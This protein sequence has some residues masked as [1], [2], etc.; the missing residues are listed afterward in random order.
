MTLEE[1]IELM[2]EL[3]QN[4][5]RADIS[6]PVGLYIETK[7]F[8]FYQ[9]TYGE[10]LAEML[11]NVLQKY[12]IETVDKANAKLPIIVEC[13]EPESLIRFAQLSD[14]PLI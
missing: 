4:Q 8:N 11:F 6:M 7:M 9:N 2:L 5:P 10:D 12:N 14:L 1:T 13:F 3:N